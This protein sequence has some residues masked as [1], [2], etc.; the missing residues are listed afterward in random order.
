MGELKERIQAES[1]RV[2][3]E[4][5]GFARLEPPPHAAFVRQWLTACIAY[6]GIQVCELFVWASDVGLLASGRPGN[7]GPEIQGLRPEA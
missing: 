7:S 4:L 3:F 5:C 6:V 1:D 2:G